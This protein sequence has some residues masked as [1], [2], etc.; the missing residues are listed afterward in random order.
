MRL[1]PVLVTAAVGLLL[2]LVESS[3][4][5]TTLPL[6]QLWQHKDNDSFPCIVIDPPWCP[7]GPPHAPSCAPVPPWGDGCPHCAANS[8]LASIMAIR[9]YRGHPG[10]PCSQDCLYDRN[11]TTDGEIPLDSVLQT[12][13]V[14][15]RD[16]ELIAAFR[17]ALTELHT[18]QNDLAVP[19][20][21][22]TAW[23]LRQL[24]TMGTPVLWIDRDGFPVAYMNP[25]AYEN[26][27]DRG[28]GHV[29]VI[30]GYDDRGSY[31]DVADD[32]VLI[33]DPWPAAGSPYPD[34]PYWVEASDVVTGDESD[35]FLADHVGGVVVAVTESSTAT[36]WSNARRLVRNPVDGSFNVLFASAGG[37]YFA[38]SREPHAPGSWTTPPR[39]LDVD[40]AAHWSTEPALAISG[41]VAPATPVLYAAWVQSA[42]P[43][44][45]GEIYWSM[46]LDGGGTW[47]HPAAVATSAMDDSR[48]PSLDVDGFDALHVVWDET[49]LLPG[50]EIMYA[51]R[52]P[53]GVWSAPV[54]LSATP[55][56]ESAFASLATSYDYTEWYAPPDPAEL[57]HVAWVEAAGTG[58]ATVVYRFWD[59]AIGW[60]P[61]TTSPPEDVTGGRGGTS[62]TLVAGPD[63][64][65]RI[66]WT[67][68]QEDPADIPHSMSDVLYNHRAGGL[69]GPPVLVS[70]PDGP[71]GTASVCPT[72]AMENGPF[73]TCLCL[74]ATWEEWD[75]EHEHGD[76]WVAIRHPVTQWGDHTRVTYD[77]LPGRRFPTLAAKWGAEFTKGYDLVWTDPA[78]ADNVVCFLGTSRG[79]NGPSAIEPTPTPAPALALAARPN[80]STATVEFAGPS[81]L[82][83]RRLQVFAVDGRL[84]REL[85]PTG[86]ARWI[87]DGRS[88]AGDELPPGV[89]FARVAGARGPVRRVVLLR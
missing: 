46:S 87:W 18:F 50:R 52:S 37:I 74:H 6:P 9:E 21:R 59:P 27:R 20:P 85:A 24:I 58:A 34:S 43:G 1:H 70:P 36:A 80:P 84:V 26:M 73:C 32:R 14:G 78:L 23:V 63:Q 49:G 65:A 82:G 68:S 72:L 31:C 76:I 64:V 54:N 33:I 7:S 22:L 29:K 10:C 28:E 86:A 77:E 61:A 5:V 66:V 15:L 67:T 71:L 41:A 12:H 38:Q 42:Q 17:D 2:P 3:A 47:T 62:P 57:V 81:A 44:A 35:L 25:T 79:V 16:A 89:Y 51:R 8:A 19:A 83:G 11:K 75:L 53:T 30:A 39:R 13:G 4:T 40:I 55:N 88:T 48:R 69:W 45:P 60:V 56:T